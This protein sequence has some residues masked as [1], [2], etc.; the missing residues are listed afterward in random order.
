MVLLAIY[1]TIEDFPDPGDPSYRIALSK[2]NA[3]NILYRLFL[4]V[5]FSELKSEKSSNGKY[6]Y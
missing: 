2:D 6:F 3:L 1:S 4:V 5:G